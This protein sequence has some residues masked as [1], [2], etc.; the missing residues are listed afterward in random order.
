MIDDPQKRQETLHRLLG[1]RP[2]R[3]GC[4]GEIVHEGRVE[5]HEAKAVTP[6]SDLHVPPGA[7]VTVIRCVECGGSRRL[8]GTLDEVLAQAAAS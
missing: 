1:L 8:P 5:A 6:P 2:H 4:P 3:E 7:T